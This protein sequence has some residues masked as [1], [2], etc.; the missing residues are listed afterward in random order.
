MEKYNFFSLPFLLIS[1]SL[2]LTTSWWL[3]HLKEKSHS[4]ISQEHPLYPCFQQTYPKLIV[5]PGPTF[6]QLKSSFNPL[7]T[8]EAYWSAEV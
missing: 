4:E 5:V 8:R 7:L 1:L 3:D 2:C 6:Q